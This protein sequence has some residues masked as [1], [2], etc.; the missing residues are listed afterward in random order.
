MKRSIISALVVSLAFVGIGTIADTVAGRVKSDE[1]ALEIMKKARLAIGGDDAIAGV[2]SMVIKGQT[3]KTISMNGA[4]R[5]E[6]G[7]TE[8]VFEY[9]NRLMKMVKLGDPSA[10]AGDGL[11]E[12]NIEVVVVGSGTGEKTVTLEGKDGEFTTDDGKK[13]MIRRTDGGEFTPAEGEAKVFVR[14]RSD[15]G[16]WSAAESDAKDGKAIILKK[17]AD[18]NA[19]WSSED[20]RKVILN[21]EVSGAA[22][23]GRDNELLR[24]TLSLLLSAPDDMDVSYTFAGETTIEGTAANAVLAS[25]GG[26]NVKLYFD[27]YS[28]LPLAMSY[29]G[30][31]SPAIVKFK[32]EGGDPNA[33]ADV[34]T[35]SRKIGAP[36]ENVENF[37]RF[38]DYRSTNGVLLPYKWTT[39]VGGKVS[40]V[41]DVSSFEV[42]PTNISE[43][44]KG[45]GMKI[46]MKRP[47]DNK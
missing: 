44:F 3:S 1:K 2:R 20:G 7:E 8:I 29:I 33:K 5:I 39:T 31:P 32:K 9:P 27:R 18:G 34:V 19:V 47:A 10:A 25:F 46:R 40:E 12:K 35:F 23:H 14:K 45:E 24:T 38:S 21:E 13:I 16:E 41:F 17:G 30:H 15:G 26:A 28:N 11:A 36:G 42:N 37:I 22:I 4:E 43:R 6:Q